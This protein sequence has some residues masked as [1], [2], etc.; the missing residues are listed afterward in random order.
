L[1]YSVVKVL[2]K[3]SY[4]TDQFPIER[5][6]KI[7]KA[8]LARLKTKEATESMKQKFLQ[9]LGTLRRKESEN[10]RYTPIVDRYV[11]VSTRQRQAD[12]V[13]AA[14]LRNSKTIFHTDQ[15]RDTLVDE[16]IEFF[17]EAADSTNGYRQFLVRNYHD[18]KTPL[19]L[20]IADSENEQ[21]FI[22]ALVDPQN[23]KCYDAW[24]KSTATRFY[25]IDYA[26]KKGEHPKRSKFNPDF[27]IKV[28]NL[29]VVVEVKGDEELR[30]PS[31]E[32]RKKNEYAVAHFNRVNDNL[33]QESTPLRY[34]FTFL[35]ERNFNKFFQSLRTGTI[36]DFRSE[37]DVKLA[38]AE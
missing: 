17:D 28:G 27:F 6:E 21:R 31:E 37:L 12:S 22:K 38:E 13:S 14:E 10:V 36:A 35:T 11:T 7:V 9:A 5:L 26:W 23:V 30:E 15:T 16:Q 8:S 20:V 33:Q 32:N 3:S 2:Q 4:Y 19:N 25:E 1:A 18:F 24:L 29:I 34:K